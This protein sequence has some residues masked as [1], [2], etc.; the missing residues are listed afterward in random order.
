MKENETAWEEGENIFPITFIFYIKLRN[1]LC[2]AYLN[3]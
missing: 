2:Q 3:C 1:N